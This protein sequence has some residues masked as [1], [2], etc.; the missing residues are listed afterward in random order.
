MISKVFFHSSFF[1]L[2]FF[3]YLCSKI[4]NIYYYYGADHKNP[5]QKQ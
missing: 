1:T 2:H 3:L 4:T 5:L